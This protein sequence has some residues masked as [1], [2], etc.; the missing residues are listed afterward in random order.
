MITRRG[1]TTRSEWDC[2]YNS[3][4]DFFTE[5]MT[6]EQRFVFGSDCRARPGTSRRFSSTAFVS[7]NNRVNGINIKSLLSI[8]DKIWSNS[9]HKIIYSYHLLDY[10]ISKQIIIFVSNIYNLSNKF[11]VNLMEKL[12][13]TL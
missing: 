12:T 1:F 2:G 10:Y 4:V 3:I 5:T 8:S 9:R 11:T 6:V 13:L 7:K